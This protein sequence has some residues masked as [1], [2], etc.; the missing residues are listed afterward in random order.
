MIFVMKEQ[1]NYQVLYYRRYSSNSRKKQ[2]I[3]DKNFRGRD[4][5]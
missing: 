4:K 5:K 2:G 3:L 1:Y